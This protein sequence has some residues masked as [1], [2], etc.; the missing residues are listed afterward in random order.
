MPLWISSQSSTGICL[1]F[2]IMSAAL[3]V[4]ILSFQRQNSIS[5]RVACPATAGFRELIGGH[6]ASLWFV[7]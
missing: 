4:L 6:V 2:S 5:V 1:I 3:T 7:L